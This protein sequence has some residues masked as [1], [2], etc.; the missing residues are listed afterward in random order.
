MALPVQN[1]RAA[2]ELI[3]FAEKCPR[4]GCFARYEAS[5]EIVGGKHLYGL[6]TWE[7]GYAFQRTHDEEFSR[8]IEFEPG[9]C[10][11]TPQ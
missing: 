1:D 6:T 9:R 8:S 2:E 7:C 5:K 4:C 10:R 3:P 11:R